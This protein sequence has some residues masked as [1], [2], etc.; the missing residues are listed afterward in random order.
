MTIYYFIVVNI[1]R[2]THYSCCWPILGTSF[3]ITL[4][5]FFCTIQKKKR[6]T[7]DFKRTV[8]SS[9]IIFIKPSTIELFINWLNSF[10]LSYFIFIESDLSIKWL[11]LVILRVK[12]VFIHLLVSYW[13]N[14]F[15]INF[16][17]VYL[18]FN[19]NS[20]SDK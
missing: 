10:M 6:T 5:V 16:N 18:F 8:F 12:I 7:L 15:K 19:N 17:N 11:K 2:W 13:I 20:T 14:K 1:F 9:W 3:W 4:K